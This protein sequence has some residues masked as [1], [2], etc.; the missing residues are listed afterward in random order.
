MAS[1][2]AVSALSVTL[3]GSPVLSDVSF[4]VPRGEVLAVLG[5]SGSGKST[6]LRALAGLEPATG[7]SWDGVPVDG[8]PTHRRGFALM[9]QDGQLFDHLSVARNVA[10]PL[11]LQG[12]RDPARVASLLA[13]VGLDGFEKRMPRT[14][15]GGQRQRV[16]L[17]RALAVSPR[18]MLLDEPLSAL[19][20]SLRAR[21]AADLRGILA[22]TTAVLVTHDQDEAFGIADRVLVLEEG[23]VVRQGRRE[24]VGHQV[25]A[26]RWVLD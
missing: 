7:V 26:T 4:A 20:A 3:D 23:R 8:L 13:L 1:G 15:S 21:L 2:L 6:L 5:P 9:F 18:L 24:D 22:G 11:R 14:L 10:Y 25:T 16:A 12:V 17:A 19:D